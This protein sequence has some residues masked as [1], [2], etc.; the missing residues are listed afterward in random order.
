MRSV[1]IMVKNLWSGGGTETYILTL[2]QSL[3]KRGYRVGIYTS[4]GTWLTFFR[5]KGI[6]LHIASSYMD[7]QE[8]LKKLMSLYQ[9]L[10][11]N[12]QY[13]ISLLETL[14]PLSN[15][16]IVTIHGKYFKPDAVRKA[17]GIA[18]AVI[19]VSLPIYHYA[20][21]CGAKPAKTRLIP[22]GIAIET[23]RPKGTKS[24]RK[25]YNFPP[26]ASVIGYAGRFTSQKL[27]LGRRISRLL[28]SF[29]AR[30]SNI[31]V[32]IAGR[33]AKKYVQA[34]GRY[35]VAGLVSNMSDFYRS[36]DVVVGTG[37]VALE[38]IACGKPVLAV[39]NRGYI[40]P[41]TV[42]NFRYAWRSNFGDHQAKRVK[43]TDRQFINDL[44]NILLLKKNVVKIRT[45]QV[46]KRMI[47][48]L[49]S[50]IM[51]EKIARLYQK[52]TATISEVNVGADQAPDPIA[53]A[54]QTPDLPQN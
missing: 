41:V 42:K 22:N 30:K 10:H 17:S 2:A 25:K 24:F 50:R 8:L 35:V 11:A 15:K 43:W 54:D 36:C 16:V 4:G 29:K 32:M 23:F 1:L 26:R 52:N 19:A 14:R 18:D 45:F 46:R 21:R 34:T 28:R 5:Q 53:Y 49:S 20:V 13:S 27:P 33:H 7:S 51:I 47:R 12:D 44:N 31:R 39:G 38:A 9:V 37:R 40:G 3:Q 48:K 6:R